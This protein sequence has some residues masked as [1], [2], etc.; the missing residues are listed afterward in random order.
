MWNDVSDGIVYEDIDLTP[1]NR[2]DKMGDTFY[3]YQNIIIS[4]IKLI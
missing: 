2:I 1:M 4:T 3:W